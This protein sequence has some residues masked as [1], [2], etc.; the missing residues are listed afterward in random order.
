MQTSVT[1]KKQMLPEYNNITQIYRESELHIILS[2]KNHYKN[3]V[4]QFSQLS[5]QG[6]VKKERKKEKKPHETTKIKYKPVHPVT[7]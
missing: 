1:E 6:C 2:F 4:S 3:A 5:I 7:G